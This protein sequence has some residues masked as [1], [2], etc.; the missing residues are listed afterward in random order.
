MALKKFKPTTPSRRT[1]T[2]A[3]FSGLANKRPEK[4]LVAPKRAATGKNSYGR[5][6]NINKGGGHKKLYRIIDFKR[7]KKDVPARVAYLEYDPNRSARIALLHYADGA[8]AYI[9]APNGLKVGD[10]VV[11]GDNVEI[12]V[13]NS[14]KIKNIPLGQQI[15]NIELKV[16]AGAKLVRAAGVSAQLVGK[17]GAYCLV[18]MPSG[19]LRK[20]FAE[21]YATIGVVGNAEHKNIELGKAGRSRWLNRRPHTR[22]VAM[23]PVDHPMGGGE[24]KS[25]GGRHPCTPKGLPT[26]GYKT[27]VNKRTSKFIV[28]GRT[29]KKR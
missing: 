26:K 2:V 5:Y 11:S 15:H 1:Y 14:L 9:L 16:G 23:N 3:D 29:V 21:C 22:G 10:T 6:T 25:S 28:R 17:E 8:K 20:I 24:G 7:R 12:K 4:S 27:R 19:E 13:A 18:K